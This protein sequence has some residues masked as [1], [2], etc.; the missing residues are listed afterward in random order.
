MNH[1]LGKYH[2]KTS[3]ARGR[4]G[5][6]S[7]DW[8]NQPNVFKT[9]PDIEMFPLPRDVQF[10]SIPFSS[11]YD[12]VQAPRTSPPLRTNEI[13]QTLLLTYSLTATARHAGGQF[14]FRTTASA[15]ALYPTEMY[16]APAGISGLKD[17]LYHF[18]VGQH[19]LALLREGDFSPHVA[20]STTCDDNK[21]P[22]L[23]IFFSVIFFRSAWKYRT[24]AYRYHLLD[25]GH[26]I[27]HLTLV[28][29]A[30]GFPLV[31]SY[32]FDDSECNRLL[33]LDDSMEVLLAIA[34]IPG[35]TSVP[36]QT[37][38]PVPEIPSAWKNASRVSPSE[39]TY[40]LI[41]ELHGDGAVLGPQ[42]G[43][44]GP[45][46]GAGFS[47]GSD[48]WQ[49]LKASERWPQD[50]D[51]ADTIMRR[52][53]KRN[54]VPEPVSEASLSAL[55]HCLC[56]QD[57]DAALRPPMSDHAIS[58]GFLIGDSG[59]LEPGFYLLNRITRSIALMRAGFLTEK[60]ARIC[61][62][63]AWLTHAAVH[64]LFLADLDQL[65]RTWGSRGYRYAMLTAGRLGERLYLAATAL[66][67]GC[68]GIGAF[69]DPEAS[70]LLG[71]SETSR[72]LYLVALGPI[73]S[74]G[75]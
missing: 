8:K 1:L 65:D 53:S 32:D 45:L 12:A 2:E 33:G 21:A 70:E 6:H 57:E 29:R 58:V 24:R 60:M 3:Y 37:P 38:K 64:F 54:Y 71:L 31:L 52:R 19:A 40:P 61:L 30:F 11:L 18:S 36:S 34:G 62:D 27:E 22:L 7:L 13:S 43:K 44:E 49:K 68:C 74:G 51:F 41:V 15:G 67:L 10:P 14:Y 46:N 23:T 17:G 50:L 55:I 75:R 20:C 35:P 42:A 56:Y 73:K 9:Y 16:L 66:G 4:M 25:T 48:S 59:I 72:L 28:S 69:Y 26:V 63:Q 5:G 39:R 47:E